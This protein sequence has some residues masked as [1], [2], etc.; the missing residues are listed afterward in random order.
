METVLVRERFG[1][2]H[3]ALAAVVLAV[4]VSIIVAGLIAVLSGTST[5]RGIVLS[6]LSTNTTSPYNDV[7]ARQE[8]RAE[9]H[10]VSTNTTSPSDNLRARKDLRSED[11]RSSSVPLNDPPRRS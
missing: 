11:Q 7:R 4:V 10:R 2:R 1:R 5:Q 9:D 6:K 8:L 3:I